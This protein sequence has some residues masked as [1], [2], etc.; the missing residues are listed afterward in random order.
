MLNL[1]GSVPSEL[2]AVL[3]GPRSNFRWGARGGLGGLP[4]W[5]LA[6]FPAHAAL[7]NRQTVSGSAPLLMCMVF[8]YSSES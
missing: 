7:V 1:T 8:A 3:A 2:G 4:E 6:P 5:A